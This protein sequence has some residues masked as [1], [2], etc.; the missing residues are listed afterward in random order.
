MPGLESLIEQMEA[1]GVRLGAANDERQ[2]FHNPYLRTTRAVQ[3]EIDRGRFLNPEWTEQW[4]VVFA[5]LYLDAFTAADVGEP[6]DPWPVTFNAALN[7]ALPP[8]RH[9]LLGIIAHINNDLPQDL[10]AVITADEFNDENIERII[11]P[12][13]RRRCCQPGEASVDVQNPRQENP[14]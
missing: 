8:P 7:P 12:I 3:E 10:L 2:H 14:T 5:Q 1:I 13:V 6:P 11:G 9:V 4:D